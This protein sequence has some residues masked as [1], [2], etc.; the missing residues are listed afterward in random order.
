MSLTAVILAAG[1]SKRMKSALPKPLHPVCGRPMLAYILDAAF[2]A[3]ADKAVLVVGHGK[4]QIVD[5]FG[6]DQ[7][8]AFV[9]QT[10]RL[11][12]GHAV[13]TAVPA[14]PDE[15]DVVV[16]AG[17]L[18]LI[19]GESLKQ[20]VD[21]HR[22][23]GAAIS[24]AT[25]VVP[26]PFGYGRVIRDD[27]GAFV[28]IVEQAD[29]S[30]EEAAVTEVFPSITMGT[31]RGLTDALDGLSND[32]A[33]GEY[34]FTDVFEITRNAGGRV[35]AVSC[36]GPDDIVAPNNRAQLAEAGRVM[37]GRILEQHMANGVGVPHP[38]TVVIEHGV[39]IGQDAT[40]LPFS[41]IGKGA[42]I[43][44]GCTIGPFAYVADDAVISEGESVAG[45]PDR[46]AMSGTLG[47]LA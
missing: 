47:G 2:D 7:R 33:Q 31:V 41:Y 45:N 36:I 14:L 8:I 6:G 24:M 20:L 26:N 23:A 13:M 30:P 21:E 35:L 12:T 19:R 18:P 43:G 16:L 1:Q 22:E 44:P 5:A 25:A 4:E 29:A 3:G 27:G 28:K 10:Q 15:G 39:T 37:Q 11:G 38:A 40:I 17:D 46:A 34:Y 42:A 9:E 32:N